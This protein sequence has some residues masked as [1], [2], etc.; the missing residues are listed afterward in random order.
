[1]LDRMSLKNLLFIFAFFVSSI[2]YGYSQIS[3]GNDLFDYCKE[4]DKDSQDTNFLSA[5][6]CMGFIKGIVGSSLFESCPS[7]GVTV[8]QAV[9]VFLRYANTHPQDLNL[10]ADLLV[11]RALSQAWPCGGVS[12]LPVHRGS[13]Y[14]P[15]RDG[16]GFLIDMVYN[17]NSPTLIAYWYT[18]NQGQ[19]MWLVGAAPH[20]WGV[21]SVQMDMYVTDGPNFG[22]AFNPAD[23]NRTPWGTVTFSFPSCNS[24]VVSYTSQL[25][26]GSGTRSNSVV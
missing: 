15:N 21:T 17:G 1:M 8:G 12:T 11:R 23:V 7:S 6:S 22:D 16:E 19:Q 4:V 25:G 3:T 2:P 18:Y 20:S 13:W 26:H 9:D 14:N 5:G 10:P 24:A